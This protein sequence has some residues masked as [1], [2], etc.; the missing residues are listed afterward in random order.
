MIARVPATSAN[1][2]PGF[3]ALGMAL[4]LGAEVGILADGEPVPDGAHLADDHH[5]AT[6]G[7]RLLHGEGRLWV[8]SPIPMGRG[9]GY[10]AA[11]RVGG[12]MLACGQRDGVNPHSDATAVVACVQSN[13]PEVLFHATSLEGHADN[14]APAVLGGVV[15]SAGEHSVRIP[16]GFDPAVVVWVPSF[17]TRTDHSRSMLGAD[18]SMADAAFNIGHV[19]LLVAALVQGDVPMLRHAMQDRLH[20]EQR[21]RAAPASQ[22]AHAAALD[23]GAW[24]AWLSGSG[25]TVAALCA[26]EN[27]DALAS[28][29]TLALTSEPGTDGHA[30]VLRIDYRGATL[31]I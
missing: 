12:L 9:L 2:G 30:K 16:M 17:T 1:L 31:T 3:D 29:L 15:A 10:S 21:F 27:A 26:T 6:V 8:R 22:A 18:V 19:A 5:L 28:V 11:V 7:F 23:A 25:P 14:A 13:A 24:C 4:S 20:Q